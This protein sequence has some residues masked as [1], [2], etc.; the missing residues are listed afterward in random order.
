MLELAADANGLPGIDSD[1]VYFTGV[2]VL[3]FSGFVVNDPDR[4]TYT[5]QV[6][7][8]GFGWNG[9]NDSTL[10]D[11]LLADSATDNNDR[12]SVIKRNDG[13]EWRLYEGE[14]NWLMLEYTAIPEPSVC[15]AIL[16]AF[17]LALAAYRR[18]R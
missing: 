9:D 10:I 1:R 13:D 5:Y 14:N 6:L 2:L 7:R 11:G 8:S 4:K 3:D 18:R 12:V 16:G 15:A 17:A